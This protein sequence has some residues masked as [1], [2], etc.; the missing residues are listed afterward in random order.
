MSMY[1]RGL[2]SSTSYC[3]DP[4]TGAGGAAAAVA[5]ATPQAGA[6]GGAGGQQQQQ[7]QKPV[8]PGNPLDA[9][10]D[11]WEPAKKPDP[12]AG[13]TPPVPGAS[14]DDG[15]E[16]VNN[17]FNSQD[18]VKGSGIDTDV[19]KAAFEKQDF[20]GFMDGMNDIMR[21]FHRTLLGNMDTVAKQHSNEAGTSAYNRSMAGFQNASNVEKLMQAIPQVNHPSLRPVAVGMLNTALSKNISLDKAIETVKAYYEAVGATFTKAPPSGRGQGAG[22]GTGDNSGG[23]SGGATDMDFDAIFSGG[24]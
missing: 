5:A 7:Q 16:R 17:Y 10:A 12:A 1:K 8:K 19:L 3:R 22:G 13:A 21:G 6:D 18:Y 23:D 15:S 2:F 14:Q 20:K 4:N 11:I 9:V 24:T